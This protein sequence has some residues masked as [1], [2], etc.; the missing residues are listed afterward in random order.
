MDTDKYKDLKKQI[1]ERKEKGTKF[2]DELRE[3]RKEKKKLEGIISMIDQQIEKEKL[4]KKR[5][6]LI[7]QKKKYENIISAKD[8]QIEK[9]R[10][11]IGKN[12]EEQLK[13]ESEIERYLEERLEGGLEGL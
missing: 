7:E 12:D 2:M 9:K 13:L 8:Q 5:S 1:E 11:E 4:E 3:L 6:K 10:N